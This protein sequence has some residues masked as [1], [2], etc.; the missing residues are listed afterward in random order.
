MLYE[1]QEEE[2]RKVLE[3]CRKGN[4]RLVEDILNKGG[5]LV[6]DHDDDDVT[7]LQA[8]A[9]GGH[10]DLVSRKQKYG[11]SPEALLLLHL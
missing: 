6:D 9:A 4:T 11:E 10:L 2:V 7:P 1:E 3:L 8:A 5:I